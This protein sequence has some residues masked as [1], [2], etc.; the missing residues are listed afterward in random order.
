MEMGRAG[1]AFLKMARS[2]RVKHRPCQWKTKL[3]NH[4]KR[5]KENK[6]HR[7]PQMATT[8]VAAVGIPPVIK[9]WFPIPTFYNHRA[10]D[11]QQQEKVHLSEW[12]CYVQNIRISPQKRHCSIHYQNKWQQL[13][14]RYCKRT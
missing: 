9:I 5:Q 8:E 10:T 7:S 4:N 13:I 11:L 6:A 14:E 3:T 12:E 1:R 2:K